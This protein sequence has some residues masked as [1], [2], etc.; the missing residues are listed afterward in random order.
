[1]PRPQLLEPD[2]AYAL[3]APGYPARAHNP[4]MQAEERAMLE[5]MPA[6]LQGQVVLDVGCGSGRYMLHALRRGAPRVTGVDPSPSMLQR[7]GTELSALPCDA[8]VVLL[9]GSLAALPVP[10]A[11]ARTAGC[12]RPLTWVRRGA[13]RHLADTR[14]PKPPVGSGGTVGSIVLGLCVWQW[15]ASVRCCPRTARATHVGFLR[16]KHG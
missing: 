16:E 15:A 2:D 14:A 11:G 4:V 1:M 6:A 8:E 13:A 5:L 3:W 7:A 9:Q 10:A 12:D